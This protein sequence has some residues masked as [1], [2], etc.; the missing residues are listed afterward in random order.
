MKLDNFPV[1]KFILLETLF[2]ISHF[3]HIYVSSILC[4]ML[5]H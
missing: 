4:G 5:T 1:F 2:F 3:A